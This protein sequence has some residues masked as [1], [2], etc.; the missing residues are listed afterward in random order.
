MTAQ[1]NPFDCDKIEQYRQTVMER[2]VLDQMI[3][4]KNI[5]GVGEGLTLAKYLFLHGKRQGR[6]LL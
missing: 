4:E 2:D 1:D 6:M 5:A 3:G